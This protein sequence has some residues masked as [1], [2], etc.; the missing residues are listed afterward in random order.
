MPTPTRA[1]AR[2]AR[3]RARRRGRARRR[4]SA[5]SRATARRCGAGASSRPPSSSAIASILVPPRSTPIRIMGSASVAARARSTRSAGAPPRPGLASRALRGAPEGSR[6]PSACSRARDRTIPG[7]PARPRWGRR[8]RRRTARRPPCRRRACRC[9]RRR[10]RG[11][12]SA[13][14]CAKASPSLVLSTTSHRLSASMRGAGGGIGGVDQAEVRERVD[15]RRVADL[16]RAR[17]VVL[18]AFERDGARRRPSACT[19]SCRCRRPGRGRARRRGT[20][21]RARAGARSRRRRSRASRRR[22]D[23]RRGAAPAPLRTRPGRTARAVRR[24]RAGR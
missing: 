12:S 19:R 23:R 6:R 22:R 20:R 7:R 10:R 24:C 13:R 8:R 3:L 2:R 1:R 15:D 14:P 17:I 18:A 16:D 5:R 11:R 9:A 21:R 4:S